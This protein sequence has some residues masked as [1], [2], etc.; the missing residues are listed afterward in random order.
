MMSITVLVST[1]ELTNFLVP[2]AI[3][4]Y[5]GEVMIFEMATYPESLNA[6]YLTCCRSWFC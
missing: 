4:I 3:L 5:F 2:I 6:N 1:V